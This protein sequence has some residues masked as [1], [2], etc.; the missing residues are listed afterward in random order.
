MEFDPH[1]DG[2]RWVGYFDLLGMRKTVEDGRYRHVFEAYQQAVEQLER[3]G[4]EHSRVHHTWFSDTFLLA[5]K[6][7]SGPSFSEIEQVSRWFVCF[8][9]Q[10]RIPLRGAIACG[11]MYADFK[12]RIFV[13]EGL[14][15][16]YLYGEAQDWIGFVLCPSAA[17]AMERLGVPANQRPHYGLWT[18]AWRDGPPKGAPDRLAACLLG[19]WMTLNGKNP[20]RA[21]LH[22]MAAA[23]PEGAIRAKYHR[24]IRFIDE[25]P[26]RIVNDG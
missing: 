6:D 22:E 11:H 18:P 15:E 12:D 7:D 19:S 16:A 14:V 25:N 26:R 4:A 23:A 5:T 10:A 20:I 21:R 8:L 13:G 17:A 1:H 3:R 2:L 24:A 9:I